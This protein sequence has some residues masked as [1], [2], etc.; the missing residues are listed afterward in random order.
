[1]ADLQMSFKN[2]MDDL[3]KNINNKEDLDYIKTQIYNISVLF[4][5]ELDKLANLNINKIDTLMAKYEDINERVEN[6]EKT[7]NHIQ[8]DIYIDDEYD[9]EIEC[10]YCS[11]EFT[12][13]F[14]DEVKKE[15]N[16]PECKNLIELDW[17]EEQHDHCHG[18]CSGCHSNCNEENEY[19]SD[20]IEDYDDNED[21]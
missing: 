4:I 20:D 12:V 13:D 18:G 17:N 19:E 21:I 10:P 8:K 3:E 16:C 5:D 2:I 6:I 14:T 11:H 9:F 7:I 1:M 15:I